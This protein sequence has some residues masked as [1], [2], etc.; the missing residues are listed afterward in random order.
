MKIA[1]N[2]VETALHN[3]IFESEEE[4]EDYYLHVSQWTTILILIDLGFKYVSV[5]EEEENV[6]RDR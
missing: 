5:G 2:K 3:L 4:H 1:I 6:N